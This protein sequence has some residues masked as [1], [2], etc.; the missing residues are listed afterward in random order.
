MKPLSK[1]TVAGLMAGMILSNAGIGLAETSNPLFS[2]VDVHTTYKSGIEFLYTL[3]VIEGYKDKTYKPYKTLSRAEMLKI[4]TKASVPGTPGAPTTKCF[5]DVPVTE[6]YAPYVCWGKDHGWVTGYDNGKFFK[7]DQIVTS[8]EGVK[9]ALEAFAIPYE[10]TSDVW[11]KGPVKA[12]SAANYIPFDIHGF[13]DG[14]RRD[15]MADLVTRIVKKSDN[16]LGTYLGDREKFVVSYESMETDENVASEYLAEQDKI[17]KEQEGA[18]AE[19]AA[20]PGKPYVMVTSMGDKGST[21]I[22]LKIYESDKNGGFPIDTYVVKKLVGTTYKPVTVLS[23]KASQENYIVEG[24]NPGEIY[25]LKVSAVNSMGKEK[26][27][28]IIA[29]TM[30]DIATIT[31][32]KGAIPDKASILVTN[33]ED[34]AFTLQITPALK[35]GGSSIAGYLVEKKEGE[36]FMPYSM[37]SK[38]QSGLYVFSNLDKEK[39]YFFRIFSVNEEHE[40][41]ADSKTL[42]IIPKKSGEFQVY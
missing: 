22:M 13:N 12:A 32:N 8:V 28:D 4:L 15:Q 7:P 3:G 20:T 16:V 34:G 1:L 25:A 37:L 14:L 9:M 17:L 23:K 18:A 19:S 35:N 26:E 5:E 6:W 27:S 30:G 21:F 2:D 41:S 40:Q 31:T 24:F 42:T 36:V 39:T 33:Q 11:Y 10:K 29:F 38:N